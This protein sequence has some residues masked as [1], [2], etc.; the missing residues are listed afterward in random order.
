MSE[1]NHIHPRSDEAVGTDIPAE[2]LA[3]LYLQ[4]EDLYQQE[5]SRIAGIDTPEA[6]NAEL[7]R[8]LEEVRHPDAMTSEDPVCFDYENRFDQRFMGHE[9]RQFVRTMDNTQLKQLHLK[10]PKTYGSAIPSCLFDQAKTLHAWDALA[11][12]LKAQIRWYQDN[13]IE[14]AFYH[15][16]LPYGHYAA[17][18]LAEVHS[19]YIPLYVEYLKALP[20][21]T[22]Y[23]GTGEQIDALFQHYWDNQDEIDGGFEA[24]LPV[25][26]ARLT[27]ARGDLWEESFCEW[28]ETGM[29]EWLDDHSAIK[30]AL[31]EQVQAELTALDVDQDD[32]ESTIDLIAHTD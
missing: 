8:W 27:F 16:E 1:N 29:R 5:L 24:F 15:D 4:R 11:I 2:L 28:C 3:Q 23:E 21:M 30:Q 13:E 12:Y 22:E 14:Q 6:M 7:G 25:L 32:I 20:L 19:R 26:K 17:G 10:K 9:I 31:C 18:M